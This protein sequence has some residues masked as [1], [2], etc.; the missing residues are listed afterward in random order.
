MSE[1]VGSDCNT[2][3][4]NNKLMCL[5]CGE[6]KI[7]SFP[8]KINSM[9][10]E[11]TS[12]NKLHC[13]CEKVLVKNDDLQFLPIQERMD[14]WVKNGERGISSEVMF[15]AISG[16]LLTKYKSPPS[17]PD[18]FKRCYLLLELIP[19]WKDELF[20]LK[21]LSASW[22]SLVDDWDKFEVLLKEQMQDCV[23]NNM[24]KLMKDIGC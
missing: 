22:S 9:T 14:W 7:I 13:D 5:N 19:E 15:Q 16:Q 23:K 4:Q 6:F 2:I 10:S 11:I 20:K 17:D 1:V 18:D 12:F 21:G 3:F 24:Y 8:I